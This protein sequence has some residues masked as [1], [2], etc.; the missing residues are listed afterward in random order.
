LRVKKLLF[1]FYHTVLTTTWDLN[2]KEVTR[3]KQNIEEVVYVEDWPRDPEYEGFFPTGARAKEAI[4][5]PQDPPFNFLISDHR[6]LFKEP[7]D[8][9][10]HQFWIEIA[11]YQVGTV[12]DVEVPPAFVSFDNS[13]EKIG[14]LI[15]WFYSYPGKKIQRYID[16]GN[17]MKRIIPD[18]DLVKGRQHNFRTLSTLSKRLQDSGMLSKEWVYHWAKIFAFDTIIGNQ[19][20]HQDNWGIIWTFHLNN[21][22]IPAMLRMIKDFGIFKA[23]EVVEA[24]FSPAFDNGTSLGYEI[25]DEDIKTFDR[26]KI[27]RYI[28]KGRHHM[29]WSMGSEK[30]NHFEF[31]KKYI[32]KYPQTKKTIIMYKF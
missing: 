32:E 10:P 16:G 29:K 1:L 31:I 30:L 25:L 6:Y 13:Q 5:C 9:H 28:S 21:R 3:K 17:Y 2:E 7:W 24:R 23:T 12:M 27:H 14:A 8:R 26:D 4:F 18:F 11:A 20:R 22:S 19:D 15:E